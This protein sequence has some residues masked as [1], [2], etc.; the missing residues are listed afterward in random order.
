MYTV[1]YLGF[2]LDNLYSIFNIH[3]TNVTIKYLSIHI[4]TPEG[5]WVVYSPKQSTLIINQLIVL[6]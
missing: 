2:E 4:K 1:H 5:P 3:S 6:S